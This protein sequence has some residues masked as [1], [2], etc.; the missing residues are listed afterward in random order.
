MKGMPAKNDEF[1]GKGARLVYQNA[2]RKHP[3]ITEGIVGVPQLKV[4]RYRSLR[5]YKQ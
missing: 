1:Q 3:K 5:D 2:H 4:H